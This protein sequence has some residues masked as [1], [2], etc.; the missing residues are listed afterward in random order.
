M[1]EAIYTLPESPPATAP[2]PSTEGSYVYNPAMSAEG[3]AQLIEFFR[4]PR[5]LALLDILLAEVQ[6]VEDANWAMHNAFDVDTAVGDQLDIIGRDVGELRNDRDDTDYRVA[7]KIRILINQSDGKLEQLI[8]I[9]TAANP[10]LDSEAR[11][12]YPAAILF[13]WY[14]AFPTLTPADLVRLLRQAKFGGVRLQAV[15]RNPDT[16]FIWGAVADAGS[17]SSHG[18]SKVDGTGGGVLEDVF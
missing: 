3:Q 5:W 8:D 15:I 14:G 12:A 11:E 10:D 17:V 6:L 2:T 1:A 4:T 9:V 13:R 18:F 16:G 7:V